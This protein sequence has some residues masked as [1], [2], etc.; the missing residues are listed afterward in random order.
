MSN[1]KTVEITPHDTNWSTLFEDESA[2]IKEAL[3][4]NCI[5]IYHIGSTSVPNLPAKPV[6]DI[7]PVVQ[8]ILNVDVSNARMEA[9]GYDALGEAGILFRR[10]YKKSKA[11]IGFNVHIYEKNNPEIDRYIQFRDWLKTHSDDLKKY[12]SLKQKL[13]ALF[14][15]DI[16]L[17]CH[18]KTEFILSIEDKFG[19]RG[20]RVVLACSPYEWSNYHRIRKEQ[21]FDPINVLYDENHPT[22]SDDKHVHLV[23]FKGSKITTV[24]HLEFLNDSEVA[25]RSLATDEDYQNQGF[26]KAMLVLIEKWLKQQHIKVI[27]MHARTAAVS[28]YRQLGYVDMN[29]EGSCINEDNIDLGKI[30]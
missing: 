7:L 19:W 10:F 25:L 26:G 8:D 6:I 11:T 4:D 27:K 22:I 16:T 14:P 2:A 30:L 20:L 12:A 13:A 5:E 29:F 9:L 17:Y 23:Y 28:F 15:N 18:G 3:G 1:I 24:A 21:L